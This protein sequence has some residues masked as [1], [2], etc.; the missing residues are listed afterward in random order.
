[1]APHLG[2]AYQPAN[3]Y[4]AVGT[5]LILGLLLYL[6]RRGVAKGILGLTYLI[7]YPVSQLILFNWRTDSETPA[8]LW[9]LKQAQLTSLVMLITIVPL[10]FFAWRRSRRQAQSRASSL[11]V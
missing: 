3:L 8:I 6:R 7:L 4:E 2:V 10:F 5:L 9:G 11:E 1:M